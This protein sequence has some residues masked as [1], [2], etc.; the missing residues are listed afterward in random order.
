MVGSGRAAIRAIQAACI[1]RE[2]LPAHDMVYLAIKTKF[3]HPT[4]GRKLSF[5]WHL[6]DGT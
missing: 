2:R 1:G 5:A 4:A 6:L 3:R